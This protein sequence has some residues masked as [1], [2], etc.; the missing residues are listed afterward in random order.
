MCQ[1][2]S[3]QISNFPL[4]PTQHRDIL[5][6]CNLC[7]KRFKR[8]RIMA[9]RC[10]NCFNF[11]HDVCIS[12]RSSL[13]TITENGLLCHQ[14][15]FPFALCDN[16]DDIFQNLPTVLSHG[17]TDIDCI[18]LQKGLIIGHLNIRSLNQIKI[19]QLKVYMN[20]F[21]LDIFT[22][23]ESWLNDFSTENININ[24]YTFFRK[25][26]VRRGGGLLTF[27][28]NKFA[29][30]L[31]SPD[32]IFENEV[33]Y[34][35]FSIS[36]TNTI[37]MII[38]NFYRPP[39][40]L[41]VQDS[42]FVNLNNL[43]HFAVNITN[44]ICILGDF[45]LDLCSQY[46][47]AHELAS[48]LLK[49]GLKQ[50][51]KFPTRISNNS[52]TLIDHIYYNK[53]DFVA[54]AGTLP[55]DFSDHEIVYVILKKP[56]K[57]FAPKIIHTR[58]YENLDSPLILKALQRES[59]Y[60]SIFD[61]INVNTKLRLF[62]NIC[63]S[64]IDTF[65]PTI[66]RR[67]KSR[68]T[69]PWFDK[70]IDALCHQTLN[71][72]RKINKS[73]L[74]IRQNPDSESL[75]NIRNLLLVEYK[76]LRNARNGAIKQS[77]NSFYKLKFNAAVTPK[78]SWL[79]YKTLIGDNVQ[80][81]KIISLNSDITNITDPQ[82][83]AECLADAF[84]VKKSDPT[85]FLINYHKSIIVD[86]LTD[87]TIDSEYIISLISNTKG[88]SASGIDGLPTKIIKKFINEFEPVISDIFRNSFLS[89]IF[90][91]EWKSA[92]ITPFLKK[93]GQA[94]DPLSYRP[95]ST[96]PFLSKVF[97]KYLSNLILQHMIEK[98]I[99]LNDAQYGFR[100][101]KS[102]FHAILDLTHRIY[103]LLDKN[104]FT[105]TV[106]LDLSK[107]FDSITYSKLIL[108]L[109]AKF[110][111]PDYILK[112]VV[113]YL[114]DRSFKI[115]LGDFTSKSFP[116][117][118]G[119]PQGSVLGPLLFLLYFDDMTDC[120]NEIVTLY[121]DDIASPLGDE[122]IA[123]LFQRLGSFLNNVDEW[124][125]DND[126]TL[127]AKKSKFMVFEK[128]LKFQGR[129]GKHASN[130]RIPSHFDASFGRIER[131]NSFCY[132]GINFD[133]RLTFDNHIK[134]IN[135][136][137]K[138]KAQQLISNKRA[139]TDKLFPVIFKATVL[140]HLDYALPIF[141][142]SHDLAKIQD[143]IDF[144]LKCYYVKGYC[145][146]RFQHVNTAKAKALMLRNNP[147]PTL[148]KVKIKT[149]NNTT[150]GTRDLL[151]FYEKI[152]IQTV[153]ERL[154]FL[155]LTTLYSILKGDFNKHLRHLF[156]DPKLPLR[157]SKR[158]GNITVK[159][160]SS[161]LRNGY[162]YRATV[163]FNSLPNKLKAIDDSTSRFKN[164]LKQW[165]TNGRLNDYVFF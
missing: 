93:D 120:L 88:D 132:L 26:R 4:T 149:K 29:V 70:T 145:Y 13:I 65:C 75:V 79:I 165:L 140:P 118:S 23:S 2:N 127:N 5:S 147:N 58:N 59:L 99:K 51:I 115:N 129:R 8:G 141:G 97:E 71:L 105:L 14:C 69:S 30:K 72:K 43:I 123:I 154:R 100:K 74:K 67:I 87:I 21:S 101:G 11:A 20:R 35:I 131:V 22:I 134:K 6:N 112:L 19:E 10:L 39:E 77:S 90:P 122:N 68:I 27:V 83:I 89:G 106:F 49:Y 158:M 126:L 119:V 104:L 130:C 91:N 113:H 146:R 62:T 48:Q 1:T 42:F 32:I 64:Q 52:A 57:H 47:A 63:L 61:A 3:A 28:H 109:K 148:G 95:I 55:S 125:K 156:V 60:K 40:Y 161:F 78:Q 111:F 98:K 135:A 46:P 41:S 124:C 153:I 84:A 151:S 33:E 155:T 138:Y 96:L 121:A 17:F 159:R 36:F 144:F 82:G 81:K 117:F 143:T 139:I 162:Q 92:T 137:M 116:L 114:L 53:N 37:P 142:N 24:N 18:T 150:V 38:I 34:Q 7:S 160:T 108:K 12:S 136:K 133:T 86:S 164:E 107:A 25:D 50:L 76:K 80:P 31:L 157:S 16:E 152:G 103:E 56:K 15:V 44:D 102:T 45:N 128:P 9:Y 66:T 110:Q 94:L 85:I 73:N 163:L 54:D